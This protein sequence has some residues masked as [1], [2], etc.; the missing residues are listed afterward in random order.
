MKL[1]ISTRI[2][3]KQSIGEIKYRRMFLKSPVVILLKQFYRKK[4]FL[5][6]FAS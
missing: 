2:G 5:M 3:L 6:S 1:K 4:P